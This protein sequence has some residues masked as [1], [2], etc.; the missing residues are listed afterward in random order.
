MEISGTAIIWIRGKS[1]HFEILVED[2]S[3]SIVIKNM[4]DKINSLYSLSLTYRIHPYKG[5]GKLR[6]DLNH[7]ADPVK[8][9]LLDNLPRILN[10]YGR[11]LDKNS[12][13]IVVVD[14]DG[15]DCKIFKKELTDLLEA[16]RN[17]PV[18]VFCIA[19]EE[20]EAWLLGDRNALLTAY[21]SVNKK[22]LNSYKQDSICGTWEVMADALCKEKAAGLNE[23]VYPETGRRKCEW[24]QNISPYIDIEKN[25][26][27]S[28]NYFV[29]KI[30]SLA[31]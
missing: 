25:N 31:G 11:S 4:M 29:K 28:F 30:R 24:A 12:A 6:R 22:I 3:G 23:K 20:M 27:P 19:I 2:E 15:R 14:L 9:I 1:M 8:R 10:G 21:P 18:A 17:R 26:S 5:L 13:V 16:C 7:K